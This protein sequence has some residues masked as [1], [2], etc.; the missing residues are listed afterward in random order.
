M[1]H[2]SS[3]ECTGFI[4]RRGGTLIQVESVLLTT[5]QRGHDCDAYNYSIV[6]VPK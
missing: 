4:S 3:S 5:E 6:S 1:R 2:L